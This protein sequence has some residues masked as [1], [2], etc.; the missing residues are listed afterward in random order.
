MINL[1]LKDLVDKLLSI[2]VEELGKVKN[3]REVDQ[4]E[5]RLR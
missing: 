2:N 4:L 1:G 3:W 5:N